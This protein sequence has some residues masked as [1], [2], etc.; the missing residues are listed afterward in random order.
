MYFRKKTSGGRAYLQI[1]ESRREGAQVRQQVIATLGRVEDLRES[2]Q[3][4][5]LLRSGARF[6]AKAI[7]VDALND[8]TAISAQV[9]RIGPALVFERLWEKEIGC[10]P[11]LN[12]S[13]RLQATPSCPLLFCK[14]WP[15]QSFF[16]DY[17]YASLAAG[18]AA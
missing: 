14:D 9:R 5:R 4:E 3:L 15:V 7:V 2:G 16:A 6:A 1:V 8:G 11:P 12:S 10:R 17:M 13:W 18:R